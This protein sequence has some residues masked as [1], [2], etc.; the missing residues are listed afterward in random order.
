MMCKKKKFKGKTYEKKQFTLNLY[1]NFFE[2]ENVKLSC[3]S[4]DFESEK[5]YNIKE[6]NV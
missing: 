5:I 3:E 6:D 4:F 2:R 1:F